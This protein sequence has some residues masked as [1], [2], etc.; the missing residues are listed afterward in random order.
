MR[1]PQH[2][3]KID[4]FRAQRTPMTGHTKADGWHADDGRGGDRELWGTSKVDGKNASNVSGK[5]QHDRLPNLVAG[6]DGLRFRASLRRAI[7]LKRGIAPIALVLHLKL[8]AFR[9][10]LCPDPGIDDIVG[11][12]SHVEE[13]LMRRNLFRENP[14]LQGAVAV[15]N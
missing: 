5:R 11:N 12:P 4:F 2:L 15:F 7:S 13:R 8:V 1:R 9:L 10:Q 14:R 6:M 3:Q